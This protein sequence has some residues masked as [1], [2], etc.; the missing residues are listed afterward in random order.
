MGRSISDGI[1]LREMAIV[2]CRLRITHEANSIHKRISLQAITEISSKRKS[3]KWLTEED[4]LSVLKVTMFS[5]TRVA[6]SLILPQLS[7][8]KYTFSRL[9]PTSSLMT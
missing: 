1:S 8:I 5:K 3:F 9:I 2:N 6:H 4:P 7:K